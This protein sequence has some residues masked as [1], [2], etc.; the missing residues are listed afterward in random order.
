MAKVILTNNPKV[1]ELKNLYEQKAASKETTPAIKLTF[2]TNKN[3]KKKS[4][5]DEL[6]S[7]RSKTVANLFEEFHDASPEPEA[8]KFTLD[9]IVK[10][11]SDPTFGYNSSIVVEAKSHKNRK[12]FAD[13]F[14]EL[15]TD[16][17]DLE[18]CQLMARFI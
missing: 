1:S 7:L 17:K 15:L 2:D 14:V 18:N 10:I 12:F 8:L 13:V 4:V 3:L 9:F 6:H 16:Y 5:I 11:A